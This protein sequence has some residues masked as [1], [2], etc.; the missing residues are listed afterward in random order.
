MVRFFSCSVQIGHENTFSYPNYL[1]LICLVIATYCS[2]TYGSPG[3]WYVTDP[4]NGLVI[5]FILTV[6]AMALTGFIFPSLA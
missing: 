6:L 4:G 3:S 2:I 5:T 1:F